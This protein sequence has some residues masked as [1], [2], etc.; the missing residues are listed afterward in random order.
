MSVTTSRNISNAAAPLYT[1]C[2]RLFPFPSFVGYQQSSSCWKSV[3]RLPTTF[4]LLDIGMLW[5][6][7]AKKKVMNHITTEMHMILI[8]LPKFGVTKMRLCRRRT[9]SLIRVRTSI[10][11][12][13]KVNV[14]CSRNISCR[15]SFLRGKLEYLPLRMWW[16]FLFSS[17]SYERQFHQRW[18]LNWREYITRGISRSQLTTYKSHAI[19]DNDNLYHVKICSSQD[20]N[21]IPK[22]LGL[23]NHRHN[24]LEIWLSVRRAANRRSKC[25]VETVLC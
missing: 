24:N 19:A 10:Y 20:L 8:A 12:N 9:D 21:S 23:N 14:N 18:P 2:T 16:F 4:Q 6:R 3:T 17:P 22:P 15:T 11:V 1:S 13:C 7:V 25:T 5:S